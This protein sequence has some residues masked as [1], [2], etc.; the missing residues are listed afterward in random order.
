MSTDVGETS[1]IV[2]EVSDG[3]E[4]VYTTT[5]VVVTDSGAAIPV[6]LEKLVEEVS[7]AVVLLVRFGALVKTMTVVVD[8]NVVSVVAE[9]SDMVFEDSSVSMLIDKEVEAVDSCVISE[10]EFSEGPM[11]VVLTLKTVGLVLIRSVVVAFKL[12]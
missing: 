4:L 6:V 3:V 9:T 10:V 7:S 8:D 5:V 1:G 2:E 11:S 12:V